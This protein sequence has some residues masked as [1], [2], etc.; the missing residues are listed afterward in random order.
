MTIKGALAARLRVSQPASKQQTAVLITTQLQQ[1]RA[2]HRLQ[3]RALGGS[4]WPAK[5]SAEFRIAATMLRAVPQQALSTNCSTVTSGIESLRC[6]TAVTLP[7]PSPPSVCRPN[8][9]RNKLQ[10]IGSRDQ[11]VLLQD[12]PRLICGM[13]MIILNAVQQGGKHY[14]AEQQPAYLGHY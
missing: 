3:S 14:A 7:F 1:P 9:V 6:H 11:I 13:L 5:P 12:L 10:R 4:I 8:R 2:Q